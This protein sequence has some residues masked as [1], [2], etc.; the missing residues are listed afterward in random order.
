MYLPYF[1]EMQF[2]YSNYL[3]PERK[4]SEAVISSGARN[5]S[6]LLILKF[7]ISPFGRNDKK[8]GFRSG[9]T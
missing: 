1:L 3:V 8:W 6:V 2:F 4:L 7:K 9:T 5:L